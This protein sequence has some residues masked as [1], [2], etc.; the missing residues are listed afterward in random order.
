MTTLTRHGLAG[1]SP[2]EAREC[3]D[4]S[5]LWIGP[6]DNERAVLLAGT[7]ESGDESPHSKEAA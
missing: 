5:P 4:V 6:V 2:P 1:G 7:K 3:G